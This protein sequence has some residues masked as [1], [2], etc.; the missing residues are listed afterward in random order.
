[1]L[2]LS[3]DRCF[4][5]EIVTPRSKLH[6]VNHPRHGKVYPVATYDLSKNY[7]KLPIASFTAMGLV[8]SLVLYGT[9]INQIFTPVVQGF[10]CNPIFLIPSL[11]L[12]YYLFDKYFVFTNGARSHVLNIYLKPCGKKSIV[13]TRDGECR[14]VVHEKFYEPSVVKTRY[15]YRIDLGHDLIFSN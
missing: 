12:N 10:L 11:Y 2:H 4:S 6:F 7:Y 14:T 8:N 13:E 5:S 9:F 3:T 15:S 1:M